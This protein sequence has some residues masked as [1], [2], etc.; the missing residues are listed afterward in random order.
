[1]AAYRR[2]AL[3]GAARMH[4]T[5]PGHLRTDPHHRTRHQPIS[6][7]RPDTP[8]RPTP[9]RGPYRHRTRRHRPHPDATA[10]ARR[11]TG[12][13]RRL[14]AHFASAVTVAKVGTNCWTLVF[15]ADTAAARREMAAST[16]R[17][18]RT[19]GRKSLGV[20]RLGTICRP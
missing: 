3:G 17:C 2:G 4:R 11:G 6:D 19:D 7:H 16:A 8:P 18:A 12:D 9:G 15:A 1:M 20:R 14:S 10:P 5:R 13:P